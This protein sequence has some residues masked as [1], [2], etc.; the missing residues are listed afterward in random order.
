MSSSSTDVLDRRGWKLQHDWL[1]K[2]WTLILTSRIT[3]YPFR[4]NFNHQK[5]YTYSTLHWH[6]NAVSS[7]CFTPEG[8]HIIIFNPAVLAT[9]TKFA[10]DFVLIVLLKKKKAR[11]S[12]SCFLY[13]FWLC[14]TRH[15]PVE[16]RRGV[17]ARPVA[18]Q[19]REPAGLPASLGCRHH[20]HRRLTRRS[21][22]L[23]LTQ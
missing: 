6:S 16:R 21:S 22:V 13:L 23:H 15:Q 12:W 5:E 11:L 2:Q 14:F 17:G 1:S 9:T 10:L 4:R 7:M 8:T 18:L 19:R 3:L 20:T